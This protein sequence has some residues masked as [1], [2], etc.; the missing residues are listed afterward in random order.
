MSGRQTDDRQHWPD[1]QPSPSSRVTISCTS[2]RKLRNVWRSAMS[3]LTKEMHDAKAAN[4][5][6]PKSVDDAAVPRDNTTL[7][8]DGRMSVYDDET[9]GDPYNRAGRFNRINR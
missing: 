9:G 7:Q 2:K 1:D 6:L 8:F 5:P 4:P 3:V